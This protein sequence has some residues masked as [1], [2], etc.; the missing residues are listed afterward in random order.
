MSDTDTTA[1]EHREWTYD[2][3]VFDAIKDSIGAQEE[4]VDRWAQA[5]QDL[6]Q[7]S[8]GDLWMDTVEG[9]ALAYEVWMVAAQHTAER[10]ADL[11]AGEDVPLEEFRDIWMDA[12]NDAFKELAASDAFAAALASNVEALDIVQDVDEAAQTML[13]SLGF[14][15]ESDVTEVGARLVE[16][17]RRQHNVERKLDR[18]LD[19]IEE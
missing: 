18:L 1:E 10:T 16:L 15:T 19:V 12:A 14:A 5:I 3:D 11:M 2:E 8:D 17:E 13:R 9:Y 7:R 6:S 4:F